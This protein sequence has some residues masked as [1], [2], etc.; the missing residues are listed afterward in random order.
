MNPEPQKVPEIKISDEI[1]SAQDEAKRLLT[2]SIKCS[3]CG[4]TDLMYIYY[5]S[6]LNP[7]YKLCDMC[8]GE[9]KSSQV[10]LQIWSS[11]V[12]DRYKNLIF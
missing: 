9:S 6:P 3:K 5:I 1:L 10:L 7:D 11:D 4:I 8:E 2:H 12:F